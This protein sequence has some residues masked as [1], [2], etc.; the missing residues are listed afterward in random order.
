MYAE[1]VYC[2]SHTGPD[3]STGCDLGANTGLREK[4]YESRLVAG[5]EADDRVFI[6]KIYVKS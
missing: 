3:P 1:P 5:E 2:R 4:N 6:I